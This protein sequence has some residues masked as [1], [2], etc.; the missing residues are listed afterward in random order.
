VVGD[1][2]ISLNGDRARIVY[3]IFPA[4]ADALGNHA[5]GVRQLKTEKGIVKVQSPVPGLPKPSVLVNASVNGLGVTQ[6]SFVF[7]DAEIAVQTLRPNARSGYVKSTL[8]LA[9]FALDHLRAVA[10]Q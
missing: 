10:R 3:V 6:V 8:S 1:V 9:G 4:Q 5:D 2:E 7:G